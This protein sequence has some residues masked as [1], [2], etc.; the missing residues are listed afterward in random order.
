MSITAASAERPMTPLAP[1]AAGASLSG[2]LY[3]AIHTAGS[4]GS[5]ESPDNDRTE[6]MSATFLDAEAG[7]N[8]VV[9][10]LRP[11]GV[12]WQAAGMESAVEAGLRTQ[13]MDWLAERMEANGGYVH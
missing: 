6:C 5:P 2:G 7:V 11:A 12:L 9:R 8:G 10:G 4:I 13:I 3:R 1:M